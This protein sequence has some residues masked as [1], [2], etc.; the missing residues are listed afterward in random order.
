M[1]EA[2][3]VPRFWNWNRLKRVIHRAA[4]GWMDDDV[5]RLSAALAY[6]AVFSIAPL[7][8]LAVAIAGAVYGPE[9]ANG[10]VDAHLRGL[11]GPKTAQIIEEMVH[12]AE[13]SSFVA[14]VIGMVTLIYGAMSLFTELNASLNLIW[15]EPAAL[16]PKKGGPIWHFFKVRLLSLGM[17]LFIGCL[18]MASL[19]FGTAMHMVHQWVGDDLSLPVDVWAVMGYGTSC[20]IEIAL[21]ALVFRGLTHVKFPWKDVWAGAIFTGVLFEA[22]KLGLSWYLGRETFSSTYGA[23]A[24]LMVLLVWANYSSIILLTGAEITEAWSMVRLE[25]TREKKKEA[26]AEVTTE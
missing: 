13:K 23:A 4:N 9:A 20:A 22:G 10:Q 2:V 5:P 26:A 18:L 1:S 14:T 11:V 17:I 12:N 8:L 6:Y 15:H 16:H 25:L 19:F 7:L 21:F 3:R 24:S